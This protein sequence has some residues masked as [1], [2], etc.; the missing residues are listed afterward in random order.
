MKKTT[1]TVIIRLGIVSFM[2]MF[3]FAIL[4]VHSNWQT[5]VGVFFMLTAYSLEKKFSNL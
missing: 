1:K 2:Y 3:S 5:A 4:A